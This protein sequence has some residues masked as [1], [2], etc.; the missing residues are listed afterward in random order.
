MVAKHGA[1]EVKPCKNGTK[2][3]PSG[4]LRCYAVVGTSG[5]CRVAVLSIADG[6]LS[7]AF[8]DTSRADRAISGWVRVQDDG[9]GT[10]HI[11]VEVSF[12]GHI[13]RINT[14][15]AAFSSARARG[16][17]DSR[18]RDAGRGFVHAS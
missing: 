14:Y 8:C 7:G 4:R 18:P 15:S 9:E 12:L 6:T 16:R 17:R 3:E 1:L 13:G 2:A 11:H 10:A 5:V